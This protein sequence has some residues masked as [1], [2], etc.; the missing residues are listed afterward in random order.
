MFH[1][2]NIRHIFDMFSFRFLAFSNDTLY[3]L[4]R[5]NNKG[6]INIMFDLTNIIRLTSAISFFSNHQSYILPRTNKKFILFV[7]NAM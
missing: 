6:N 7:T 1:L 4:P 3:L 5:T 2:K